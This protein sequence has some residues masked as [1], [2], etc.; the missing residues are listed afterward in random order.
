MNLVN[1]APCLHESAECFLIHKQNYTMKKISVFVLLIFMACFGLQ[2]QNEKSPTNSK[3]GN[4]KND[5]KPA[6]TNTQVT[7]GQA[8][9]QDPK[10][11]NYDELVKKVE[12][13]KKAQAAKI[14]KGEKQPKLEPKLSPSRR[15]ANA[16]ATKGALAKKAEYPKPDLAKLGI[17]EQDYQNALKDPAAA[18]QKLEHGKARLELAYKSGK[19]TRSQY[20]T[21]MSQI[22]LYN[23]ELDKIEAFN[24]SGSTPTT[25]S[26][27]TPKK[28][29][30]TLKPATKTKK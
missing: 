14:A 30:G 3:T 25:P 13:A 7:V 24:K 9:N 22:G 11:A 29:T 17:T 28:P 6:S 1:F 2:A 18:R 27:T 8:S 12:A 20:E 26:T 10:P 16:N 23:K 4:T 15:K 21:K 19:I 5:S